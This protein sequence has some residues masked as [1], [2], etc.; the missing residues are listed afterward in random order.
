MVLVDLETRFRLF[1]DCHGLIFSA[2]LVARTIPLER[3]TPAE[4]VMTWHFEQ[5]LIAQVVGMVYMYSFAP[6]LIISIF[7]SW[8]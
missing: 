4:L 7:A 6:M 3:F 2:C 8:S 1:S 5:F